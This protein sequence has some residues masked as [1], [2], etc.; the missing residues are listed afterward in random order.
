MSQSATGAIAAE[1]AE[2]VRPC[3]VCG[4]CHIVLLR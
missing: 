1:E 3:I 4:P 2:R